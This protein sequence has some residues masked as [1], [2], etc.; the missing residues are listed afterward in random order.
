MREFMTQYKDVLFSDDVAKM[1]SEIVIDT[2]ELYEI[3]LLFFK[4]T[5]QAKAVSIT[6]IVENVIVNRR[7]AKSKGRRTFYEETQTNIARGAAIKAVEQLEK[8]SLIYSEPVQRTFVYYLTERG[9]QLSPYILQHYK[10]SK[11]NVAV[12]STTTKDEVSEN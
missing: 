5:Q 12:F 9:V 8:M 4:M 7:V 3:M 2:P 10:E 11:T 1:F 6:T